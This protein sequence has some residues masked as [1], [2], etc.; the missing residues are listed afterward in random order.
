MIRKLSTI[1]IMLLAMNIFT[2]GLAFAKSDIDGHWA[3][4]QMNYL[5]EE[6]I[7]HGYEGGKYKP[8]GQVTRAEFT[9]FLDRSLGL[10]TPADISFPDVKSTHW[11]YGSVAR[12]VHSGLV[13]GDEKGY[14]NPNNNISRQEMASMLK[15][16]LEYLNIEGKDMTFVFTDSDSIAKWATDDVNYVLSVGIMAGQPNNK[17][18]PL[19]NATR[20]EAAAVLYRVLHFDPETAGPIVEAKQIIKTQFEADYNTTLVKQANH[21]PKL[22]GSAVFIASAPMVNY[23]LNPQQFKQDSP[24]FYQFLKLSKAVK[25]L[26]AKTINDKVLGDKGVLVGKADSFIRAGNEFEIN[27]VYLMSHAL[28][29]TGNGKSPLAKGIEVGLD[30]NGKATMVTTENREA[31][32]DIKVTYNMYG[33]GAVDADAN[34]FGSER[35][36]NEGWVTVDSAIVGGAQFVKEKYIGNKYGQ[37]TLYKMKWNPANPTYPQYATHVQWAVIQAKIIHEIYVKIQADKTTLS[38]FDVPV[39]KNQPAPIAMPDIVDRYA[40]DDT[41][42]GKKAKV[43]VEYNIPLNV[44][45]YPSTSAPLLGTLPNETEVTILGENG[46][47]FK[48]EVNGMQGWV[49]GLYLQIE[50]VTPPPVKALNTATFSNLIEPGDHEAQQLL[51]EL[52]ESLYLQE[53][54]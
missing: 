43:A 39:Y 41:L 24:E 36:Y 52:E 20:A 6:G 4:N 45:S 30:E 5:I 7:M 11:Y 32:K 21:T 16:T 53:E 3:Y 44:R 49:S 27:A 25:N 2:M 51:E 10:E 1:F 50:G 38:V 34:K 14:F 13:K 48:I 29:E 15:R 54:K 47:W 31:L 37:D 22:D 9:A 18:A 23:Y 28:H 12:A 19:A 40:V 35:A 42:K 46:K 26:N 8:D 17:F 33:I